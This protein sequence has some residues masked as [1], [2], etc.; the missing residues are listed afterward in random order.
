MA[1]C[2]R[3]SF[4]FNAVA[5]A[6]GLQWLGFGDLAPGCLYTAA[7]LALTVFEVS[8]AGSLL[9]S[10]Q[11]CQQTVPLPLPRTAL[12]LSRFL[13][14]YLTDLACCTLLLGP[15]LCLCISQAGI[16][17]AAVPIALLGLLLLP[18]LPLCFASLLGAAILAGTSRLRHGNII[19][20]L[21]LLIATLL[22]LVLCFGTTIGMPTDEAEFLS[23]LEPVL[24]QCI[25]L[26]PPADWLTRALAGRFIWLVPLCLISL[27]PA[28]LLFGLA[29]PRYPKLCAA[30]H[31]GSAKRAA[32]ALPQRTGR[33]VT[34]LYRREW[35][36]YLSCGIYLT[37][38]LVG[39]LLLVL[40]AAGYRL[41]GPQ[42]F[43][44][45]RP[46]G[47]GYQLSAACSGV[48]GLSGAAFG[49]LCLAG[50]AAM[51]PPAQF[52]HPPRR[53]CS[54]QT[55]PE[56]DC[57]CPLLDGYQFAA[58]WYPR[59]PD[60]TQLFPGLYLV[61]GAVMGPER[62][63]ASSPF[64]LGKRSAG[65]QTKRRHTCDTA[66]RHRDGRRASSRPVGLAGRLCLP[67][68]FASLCW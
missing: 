39:Y 23:L 19:G 21:L 52:A 41:V 14:V 67:R 17:L 26:Y 59:R 64:E 62:Q 35:Q 54:Q 10:D 4:C 8:R 31:T 45:A 34:A 48:V 44:S 20:S 22:V 16:G 37:N 68:S 25:A 47:G 13:T 11:F 56:P 6:Y 2:L 9:F 5:I 3:C 18:L 27:L 40:L 12:L 57:R 36:R 42:M 53:L 29:A 51:G 38:T 55:S 63:P 33:P 50:W 1:P 7:A 66:G 28:V 60:G 15:S 43:C 24:L 61:W 65:C 49:M 46:A 32:S 58:V 30:L